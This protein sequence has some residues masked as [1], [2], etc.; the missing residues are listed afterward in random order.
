MAE[1]ANQNPEELINFVYYIWWI[2]SNIQPNDVHNDVYKQSLQYT[3]DLF[4]Q[5]LRQYKIYWRFYQ[6]LNCIGTPNDPIEVAPG[7]NNTLLN[8]RVKQQ[9]ELL[10]DD[11]YQQTWQNLG[12]GDSK[13]A[14][15]L[16]TRYHFVKSFNPWINWHKIVCRLKSRQEVPPN[17]GYDYEI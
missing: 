8:E 11:N 6:I 5:L 7:F 10:F 9:L 17:M 15:Y 14:V 1:S 16:R 2:S 4:E 13:Y 3:L 12:E